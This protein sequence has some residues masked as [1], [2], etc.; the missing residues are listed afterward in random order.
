MPAQLGRE[1]V[2][3]ERRRRSPGLL[4]AVLSAAA[5]IWILAAWRNG[6]LQAASAELLFL[7]N[8]P[9][10][11]KGK[12]LE[13]NVKSTQ[14]S[15]RRNLILQS[16]LDIFHENGIH[17]LKGEEI[18]QLT[19]HAMEKIM[20]NGIWRPNW[21][22]KTM[23][24]T[25]DAER[26]SESYGGKSWKNHCLPP[27]LSTAKPPETLLQPDISPGNCWAFPRSQGHVVIR[28]PEEI[29]LTALTIWHISRAVSPSGEVSSAPREFAVSGVDEAG[30]ETLLGLFIYDVDGEIAQTFHLQEEPRKAF[31]H[32]KLE[33][34][35]NWGNAEHTCVY[36]V[37]IHGNSQ[38]TAEI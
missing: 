19:Q 7:G 8:S 28:L 4:L 25:V 29:Q 31:G 35:S 16:V 9:V 1:G 23:G 37:E 32:V 21:A 3:Q 34:W 12:E 26:T 2:A 14:L 11:R 24:A 30:G 13:L 5:F 22:L 6:I 18:L 33:V 17:R 15:A 36:R 20:E 10:W 27:L 38:K